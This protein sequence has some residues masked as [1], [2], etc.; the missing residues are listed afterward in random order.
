MDCR[1]RAAAVS[2]LTL[3]LAPTSALRALP[4][5]MGGAARRPVAANRNARRNYEILAEYEA[6][7]SLLGTEVKSCRA[8][9]V[10]LR[11]GYVKIKDGQAWLENVHVARH[12]TTGAFFNHDETRPR[13]LLL[14]KREIA[15]LRQGVERQGFTIVPLSAYFNE[16]GLL[17]LTIAL[18]RGKQ[19]Q[20]KRE[21]LKRKAV[22]REVSRQIKGFR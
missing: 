9:K 16:R 4:L 21:D 1:A 14:H 3:S 13:Q 11:D 18:G 19:L 6:G 22:E 20:D 5:M 2:L 7:V 8:G 15:K 17:K 10:N 12:D